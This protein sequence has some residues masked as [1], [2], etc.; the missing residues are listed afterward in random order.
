MD[1]DVLYL[2]PRPLKVESA[3]AIYDEAIAIISARLIRTSSLVADLHNWVAGPLLVMPIREEVERKWQPLRVT[4]KHGGRFF[5]RSWIWLK[6]VTV[7][8]IGYVKLL[9]S[10]TARIDRVRKKPI[11]AR[12]G[13]GLLWLVD[14]IA[15]TLE[16]YERR[17]RWA[18]GQ[19]GMPFGR[20]RASAS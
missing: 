6:N 11:Y 8:R 16:A 13:V 2:P 14:P 19:R 4:T 12:E 7:S 1:G 10:Q 3:N 5:R 18:V 9:S 20:C 17:R 15:R